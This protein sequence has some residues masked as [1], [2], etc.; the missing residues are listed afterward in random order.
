MNIW[1]K[2]CERLKSAPSGYEY[3][4]K[5]LKVNTHIHSPYSF[6]SFDSIEAIVEQAGREGVSVIG[7]NDF[8]TMNG[9]DEWAEKTI[10]N[11]LL[12][13]FNIEMI[14][15]DRNMMAA[16]I[17][18]NDPDNPGRVYIS[19]KAL[20]YPVSLPDDD[21]ERLRRILELSNHRVA[22][23]TDKL[24]VLL[25]TIEPGMA[26]N[27][28]EMVADHTKGMVSERHLARAIRIEAEKRF[29][30]NSSRT[31][32]M[33]KLVGEGYHNI[34]TG[35]DAEI[36]NYIR[37]GLLKSGR[38]AFIREDPE[39]FMEHGA[40][41]DLIIAAGGIPTYPFLADFNDGMYTDFESDISRA[42]ETLKREGFFSVE[43]IPGRNDYT[44]FREYAMYLYNDG[45][46]VTFGTEHNAP[47]T[48]PVEVIA[49]DNYPLDD[50]LLKINYESASILAAHQYLNS[51]Q[52]DGYLN[53]NGIPR[54]ERKDEFVTLGNSIIHMVNNTK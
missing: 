46:I 24:N 3:D 10:S 2:I 28:N 41:K 21:Q 34:N 15:L 25:D 49:G 40:I 6:S 18:I 22:L 29:M 23:M 13:L 53:G 16:G 39:I 52:G 14:G 31:G 48:K 43:F 11:K 36:E 45:F 19:G 47:G 50:D 38:P 37:S 51:L 1:H 54:R 17:R 42:A 30:D 32:F 44:R 8:N 27:Y 20:S 12:P 7:I 26:V 9:Y 5:P 4:L 33:V 35:N